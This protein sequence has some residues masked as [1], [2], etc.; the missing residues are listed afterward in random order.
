MR[1][2]FDLAER[3]RSA[4]HRTWGLLTPHSEPNAPHE[5]ADRPS[6]SLDVWCWLTR[7]DVDPGDPAGYLRAICLG[8]FVDRLPEE[9]REPFVAAALQRLPEPFEIHYVRLNIL[10]RA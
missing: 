2:G 3:A 5:T 8:S 10:A 4:P 7:L 9:L 1:D 6:R